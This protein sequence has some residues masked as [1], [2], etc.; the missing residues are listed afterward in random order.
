MAVEWAKTKKQE[1]HKYL[2]KLGEAISRLFELNE[3]GD[4]TEEESQK[5]EILEG[6]KN[7][8]FDLIYLFIF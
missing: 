1:I 2:I 8:L 3:R 5:L 7:N 6:T 4:F